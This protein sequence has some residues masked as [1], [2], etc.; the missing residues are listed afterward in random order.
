MS[1]SKVAVIVGIILISVGIIGVIP[2]GIYMTRD[3][4]LDV[5]NARNEKMSSENYIAIGEEEKVIENLKIVSKNEISQSLNIVIK[6]ST[7]NTFSIRKY[8]GFFDDIDVTYQYDESSK[9]IIV[10]TNRKRD[11]F[12]FDRV[13]DGLLKNFYDEAISALANGRSIDSNYIEV[14]VPSRVNIDIDRNGYTS[15]TVRDEEVLGDNL[16]YNI[17]FGEISLPEFNQ[18]KN[19]NINSS[20]HVELDVREFINAEKINIVGNYVDIDSEGKSLEYAKIDKLPEEINI[21]AGYLEINSYIP[22]ANKMILDVD[23]ELYFDMPFSEYSVYGDITSKSDNL[24]LINVN[25]R[26]ENGVFKG[27]L[28]NGEKGNVEVIIK[29]CDYGEIENVSK[30]SLELDIE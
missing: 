24:Q 8:K 17:S 10:D 29:S 21:I 13:K 27:E 4:L 6:K 18:C 14:Y 1:K 7:D 30:S 23:R 26:V 16:N 5:S 20:N 15:L 11:S 28:S 2:S 9:T 25:G 19:I 12:N 3:V 22:L